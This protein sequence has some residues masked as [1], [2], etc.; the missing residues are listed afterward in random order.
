MDQASTYRVGSS[1]VPCRA[2]TLPS[3]AKPIHCSYPSSIM[4]VTNRVAA[5]VWASAVT[6]QETTSPNCAGSS[7]SGPAMAVTTP[8]LRA[9]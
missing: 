2:G 4:Y 6:A 5:S 3:G 8:L 9:R 7:P 1:A